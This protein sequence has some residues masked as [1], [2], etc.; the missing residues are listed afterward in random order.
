M[1]DNKFKAVLFDVERTLLCNRIEPSQ[2]YLDTA[3]ELGA[4]D[5]CLDAVNAELARAITAMP[6]TVDNNISLSLEWTKEFNTLLLASLGLDKKAARR[7]AKALESYYAKATSYFIYPE[8]IDVLKTLSGA[9]ISLGVIANWSENL[10]TLLK[11]L[12]IDKYFDFVVSSSELR[13]QKPDRAIFDRVLFRCGVAAEDALH[14][15]ADFDR[16]ISGALSA[17]M[18]AI[19]IN[20]QENAESELHEGVR[21]VNSLY[22]VLDICELTTHG[23]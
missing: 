2:V 19:L 8:V 20:R 12:K 4:S 16:D 17:G 5:I 15:G 22:D 23:I 14:I 9:G 11:R 3:I 13:S 6:T 10:P 7:G 21:I 18:G 1:T